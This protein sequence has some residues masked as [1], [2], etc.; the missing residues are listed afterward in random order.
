MK[1]NHEEKLEIIKQKAS[2]I[3]LSICAL[4]LLVGTGDLPI[5]ILFTAFSMVLMCSSKPI[6][7]FD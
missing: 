4:I 2:G 7:E 5:P 3:L 6:L 1:K